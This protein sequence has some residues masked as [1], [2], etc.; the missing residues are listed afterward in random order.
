[1]NTVCR[2]CATA[3]TLTLVGDGSAGPDAAPGARVPLAVLGDSDSHSYQDTLSFAQGSEERG[4]KWRATSWQWSELLARWRGDQLDFGT[5]DAW[6]QSGWRHRALTWLGQAPRTPRKMDFQYNFAISGQGCD[7]LLEQAT[8]LRD[9]IEAHPAHWENG[10]VVM[11][12]GG[13]A[14]NNPLWLEA[15]ANNPRARAVV[16]HVSLCQSA[17]TRAVALLQRAQPSLRL[18]LVGPLNDAHDPLNRTQWRTESG[19]ANIEQALAPFDQH[20]KLLESQDPV[21]RLYFDN[22]AW[23]AR[24]WVGQSDHGLPT[25]RTLQ[26]GPLTLKPDFGDAPSHLQL[27]DRHFGTAANA[28]WAQA[29]VQALQARWPD[30]NLAPIGAAELDPLWASLSS[31]ASAPAGR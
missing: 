24:Q 20:L 30:L 31:A 21:H 11:R 4:G 12:I 15:A 5:W 29:L 14:L 6:G 8:Y 23:F 26:L 18:V 17:H 7:H 13:I 10:L 28:L 19:L 2:L 3:L 25:Y 1:M 16:D 22:R 9:L 27:G